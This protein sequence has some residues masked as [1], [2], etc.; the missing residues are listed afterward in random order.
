MQVYIPYVP[1]T[2]VTLATNGDIGHDTD[3]SLEILPLQ[4]NILSS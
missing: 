4:H 2:C 3:T 1:Y